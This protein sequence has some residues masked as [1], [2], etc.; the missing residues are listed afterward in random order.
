MTGLAGFQRLNADNVTGRRVLLQ[1]ALKLRATA[2][3]MQEGLVAESY[4]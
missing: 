2:R 3:K 1:R 4:R